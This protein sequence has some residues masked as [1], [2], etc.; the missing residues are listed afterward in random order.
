MKQYYFLSSVVYIRNLRHF[1]I[2]EQPLLLEDT[3]I[4]DSKKSELAVS[5]ALA[6][7][8]QLCG[9]F[10][11]FSFLFFFTS[12]FE[13]SDGTICNMKDILGVPPPLSPSTSDNEDPDDWR[14]PSGSVACVGL[15]AALNMFSH[16][17][18]NKIVK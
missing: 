9:A 18:K 16:L 5:V 15:E 12:I 14:D 17:E 3:P 8:Q 11:S 1:R 10:V 4:D 2:E 7:Y 13:Q 6:E